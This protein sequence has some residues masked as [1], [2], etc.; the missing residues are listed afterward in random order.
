MRRT[1]ACCLVLS[2]TTLAT[3]CI[4]PGSPQ[5]YRGLSAVA[6]SD[7]YTC[8]L[9]LIDSA[10]YTV[11]SSDRAGGFL[12]ATLVE[13]SSFRD[14]LA[15][16]ILAQPES[17]TE[18]HVTAETFATVPNRDGPPTTGITKP[19]NSVTNLAVRLLARCSAPGAPPADT[20]HTS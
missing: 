11:S 15:V 8:A 2:A 7:A 4:L 12:R 1:R 20:G 14:A 18:F 6:P 5:Q 17:K 3:A 10:G 13:S 19:S 9:S 16:T